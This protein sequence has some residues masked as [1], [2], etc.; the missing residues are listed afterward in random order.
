MSGNDFFTLNS[1]NESTSTKKQGKQLPHNFFPP[2]KNSS[3]LKFKRKVVK[4]EP[5]EP[6]IMIYG[7]QVEVHVK[8]S[9]PNRNNSPLKR[10][11]SVLKKEHLN[12]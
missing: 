7:D 6:L 1:N 3:K 8:Q 11:N 5:I 2:N 12:I 10:P 9:S 4:S